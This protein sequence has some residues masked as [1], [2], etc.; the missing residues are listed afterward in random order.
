[1]Q[2]GELVTQSFSRTLPPQR[3]GS[4]TTKSGHRGP[5]YLFFRGPIKGRVW[6]TKTAD[7]AASVAM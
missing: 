4:S 3:V 5:G 7:S 2:A 6:A 1:M